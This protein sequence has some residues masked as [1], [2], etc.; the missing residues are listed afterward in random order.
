[1]LGKLGPSKIYDPK[2]STRTIGKTL[3]CDPQPFTMD[4]QP[5][6]QP[7]TLDK[8]LST[9]A[10]TSNYTVSYFIVQ[11]TSKL[12]KIINFVRSASSKAKRKRCST[13]EE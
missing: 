13:V 6:S 5:T 1:M 11:R 12:A 3:F 7:S 8:R 2:T 10:S 9:P 4:L